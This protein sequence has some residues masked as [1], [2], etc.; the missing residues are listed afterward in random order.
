MADY[1]QILYDV[2]DR[3]ALITLNRP[4]RMNAMSIKLC[5]EV[6]AAINDADTNDDVRVVVITGA[7]GKA[8]SAG[9]DL[10]DDPDDMM[11][12]GNAGP[13][14]ARERLNHDLRYTYSPWR[15]SKPVIAMIEGYCLAGALEFAQMCDLRYASED[16]SFAVSETRFA[17]GVATLVMPWIIGNRCR[18]LIYTGDTVGAEDALALGLVTRVIP[19]AR[20][21]EETM[22]VAHRMARVAL[23]TLQWNKRAIN[24]TYETMGFSAALQYGLE[25]CVMMDITPSP[26]SVQFGEIT[27]A[28]G[29]TAAIRWR[30]SQFAPF[31][32]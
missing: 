30:D 4:D 5:T 32:G 31:E 6:S 11:Q 19:K 10:K 8:F 27:R 17:N 26:E 25:A 22:R 14:E 20:L 15:C 23:P 9:Y 1:E 29:L 28:Q 21:R 24:Q 16:S 7:G 2:E 18:E 12:V 3:V 13:V